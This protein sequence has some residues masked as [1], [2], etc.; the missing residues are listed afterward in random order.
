MLQFYHTKIR[1]PILSFYLKQNLG[2]SYDGLKLTVLKGVFHPKY[3][4]SS[5][6]FYEFLKKQNFKA[7]QFIEIGCGSGFL[8]LLAYKLGAV[9]T[10]IDIDENA[11]SCTKLNF[12]KNFTAQHTAQI[13][14]S[15]VFLNINPK[16]ADIICVNPPY[17]FNEVKLQSQL[18]WNCGKNGEFFEKLF[19]QLNLFTNASTQTFLILADNCEIDR[20]KSMASDYNIVFELVFQKKIKW[21]N[22]YIFRLY[23]N[24]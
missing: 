21:E 2:F 8:S 4:F 3:Y 10:A 16:I 23:F 18:A 22:N 6:C 1:K 12:K 19:S 17:F 14:K 9:V 11:I 24:G 20:I 5:I 13:I 15:N 7:K